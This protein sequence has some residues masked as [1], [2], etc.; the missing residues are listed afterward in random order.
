MLYHAAHLSPAL[1]PLPFHLFP[2]TFHLFPSM[3]L[4]SMTGFGRG[5]ASDGAVHIEVEIATVNRKQ[6]DIALTMPR[7]LAPWESRIQS[8][9]RAQIRRGYAKVAIKAAIGAAPEPPAEALERATAQ[10]AAVRAIA[11]R[12]GLADDLTA[13]SLLA[14]PDSVVPDGSETTLDEA[15]LPLLDR[16]LGDA[17]DALVAMRRREGAAMEADLR[18]H[19]GRLAALADT[20]RARVPHIVANHREAMMRRLA[21]AGLPIPAD[22][23]SLVR[24]VALFADRCDISEELARLDSHF[25]QAEQLFAA[26]EPSGRALDFLCQEFHREITTL[27]NKAAD[28]EVSVA[29]VAFKAALEAFREQ[30]Q[31]IE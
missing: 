26:D 27:G 31:N 20:I 18:G 25:R 15:H 4:T 11:T 1:F 2:L 12:L 23:P 14:L 9:I 5:S 28:A 22:D 13:S 17:L 3:S 16:A 8:L 19:L 21:E 10:I 24:E 7:G 6:L 29:V 30:V